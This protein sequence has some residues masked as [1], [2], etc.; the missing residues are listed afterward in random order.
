MKRGIASKLML[1]GFSIL[2]LLT[3]CNSIYVP[4]NLFSE[5]LL[6]VEKDGR[7]G[8]VNTR[9]DKVIDYYFD[10]AWAFKGDYAIVERSNQYNLIGK[11]GVT[12]FEDDYEYLYH[13]LETGYLWFVEESKIG[14]MKLDGDIIVDAI[15]DVPGEDEYVYSLEYYTFFQD[16]LARVSKDGKFGY[17]NKRGNIEIEPT[18]ETAGHF[19]E[20]R[21]YFAG[22]N[23]LYGY[24]DKSGEVKIEAEY[25][26][27][28][29]FNALKQA[30]VGKDL[31]GGGTVYSIIDTSGEVIAEGFSDVMLH[32]NIYVVEKD[33]RYYLIN[34]RGKE[35]SEGT[36]DDYAFMDTFIL[37]ADLD[38]NYDPT[39]ITIFKAN[40]D[41]YFEV[42]QEDLASEEMDDILTDIDIL[43]LLF[44]PETGST[45]TL[46]SLKTSKTFE[47]DDIIQVHGDLV[48]AKRNGEYGVRTMKDVEVIDYLYSYLYF[49]DDDYIYATLDGKVGI[50]NKNGKV[51]VEF[52]Y[53]SC[54]IDY[55]PE[56]Y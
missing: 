26:H 54:S 36:F 15:Y 45:I 10:N 41:V 20:G 30:V 48:V 52:R 47:A 13:D 40:G 49:F 7:Y 53:D 32:G 33:D 8:Y 5:G 21:A 43:Y 28:E 55:N 50:L 37:L 11:D 3:G 2:F 42:A 18:F 44:V 29:E 35:I 19:Y 9:G 24:I 4:V 39:A 16:G 25:N 46:K 56:N 1:F 14:L 51:I 12:R 31:V 22:T 27:A 23:E 38:E 34:N 17:I 6:A